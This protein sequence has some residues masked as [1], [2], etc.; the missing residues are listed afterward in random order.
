M[1]IRLIKNQ[2]R[3]LYSLGKLC[4][5]AGTKRI[6]ALR[7]ISLVSAA[8]GTERERVCRENIEF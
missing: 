8:S 5:A 6:R 7:R 3:T 1:H 2:L 4:E